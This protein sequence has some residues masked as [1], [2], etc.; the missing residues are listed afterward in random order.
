MLSSI[1]LS[2]L[3][4]VL[5]LYIFTTSLKLLPAVMSHR[6]VAPSVGDLRLRLRSKLGGGHS[7][8]LLWLTARFY[9]Q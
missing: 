5:H 2:R 6:A 4:P 3:K 8:E 7:T 9:Q 1:K